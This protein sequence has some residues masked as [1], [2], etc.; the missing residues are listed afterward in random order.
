[1]PTSQA[2]PIPARRISGVDLTK[3]VSGAGSLILK[4]DSGINNSACTFGLFVDGRRFAD[5]DTGEKIRIYLTPGEHIIGSKSNGICAA[6]N[7]ETS[8][9]LAAGQTRTYRV[10]VGSGGELKLQ[11]TAF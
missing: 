7:A 11:P 2:T 4:R 5:I 6:G 3:P 1:M 8:I 9:T 10:S